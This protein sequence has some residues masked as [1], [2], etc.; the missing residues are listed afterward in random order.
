MGTKPK[1]LILR[2]KL[3]PGDIVMMSAAVRDL[4]RCYPGKFQ[5]DVRTYSPEIWDYNPYLTPLREA[6]SDVEVIDVAYPLIEQAN[7]LPNHCLHGFIDFL[8]QRLGLQIKPTE[9]KGDIHLTELEKSW[10]SQVQELTEMEIPFWIV[11]G[12]GKFDVTIKWWEHERYQQVV[13]CFQGRIQFVQVGI[14]GHH[15]PKLDGAIDLRGRTDLRQFIRLMYHSQGVLCGVTAAMHLAAAVET[16]PGHPANRPCV[17]V[18]G[19][20][21]P[22]QW[23]AYPG[24]QFIH[25]IGQLSCC[26]T[27]GCWRART[28]PLGDGDDRD[29]KERVC[30]DVVDELPRC[31][32]MISAADVVQRVEDYFEGGVA[33]FLTAEEAAAGECA[34]K[35]TAENDFQSLD[36]PPKAKKSPKPGTRARNGVILIQQGS[37]VYARMLDFSGPKHS[38]YCERHGMTFWSVR[39]DVQRERSPHWNKIVLIRQALDSGV[40]HVIWLDADTLVVDAEN[41]IR[42]SLPNGSPIGMCRHPFPFNGREGHFNSGMIVIRN[43]EESCE[44]FEEVWNRGPIDHVWQEQ[45]RINEVASLH[46]EWVEIIDDRWNSTYGVN[47]SSSPVV[48]AWHGMGAEALDRMKIEV[49]RLK[50]SEKSVRSSTHCNG[51]ARPGTFPRTNFR[52]ERNQVA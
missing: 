48:K 32:H 13:N 9:F 30:V 35:A 7:R 27:G 28:K 10:R 37:G 49:K 39:G 47:E 26:A 2:T 1:K 42:R 17:V 21:E 23:E 12:G 5:T 22:G 40:E 36:Q 4:H 16:K 24:H 44:F 3:S 43:C 50:D 14:K 46:P 18:A 19:G 33:R 25:T 29:R 15:H 38:S 8:N 6:D 31:M 11:V 52:Q 20:R 34:V 51:K 41:D 45:V